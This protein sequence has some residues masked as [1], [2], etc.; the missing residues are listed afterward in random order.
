MKN[1]LGIYMGDMD[2][3]ASGP[4]RQ[5]SREA[6]AAWHKWVAD[7]AASVVT[8]RR[9]LGQDQEDWTRMAPPT[10]ATAWRGTSS[11]R[12]R[13]TIGGREAV[14]RASALLHLSR[15]QCRGDG[16]P[17][18]SSCALGCQQANKKGHG[19][20]FSGSSAH[21]AARPKPPAPPSCEAIGGRCR[22]ECLRANLSC[23]GWV[24]K[25]TAWRA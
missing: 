10:S 20:Y 17:A 2:P 11:F 22:S 13:A 7:N 24:R 19:A 21:I 14:R 9:S 25:P 18:D 3:P 16:V 15:R 23:D 4:I 12:L 8:A 1:F 5:P 6:S